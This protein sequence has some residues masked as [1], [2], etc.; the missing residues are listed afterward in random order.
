LAGT[1]PSFL[2]A[3]FGYQS[4]D[5]IESNYLVSSNENLALYLNASLCS[6]A[7]HINIQSAIEEQKNEFVGKIIKGFPRNFLMVNFMGILPYARL[8]SNNKWIVNNGTI[9]DTYGEHF[10]CTNAL[11]T[12]I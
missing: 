12:I 10:F 5:G 4:L 3:R 2:L 1:F 7:G 6:H 9:M 11:N 8:S